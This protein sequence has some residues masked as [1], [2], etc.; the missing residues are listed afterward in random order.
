MVMTRLGRGCS[1]CLQPPLF[2]RNVGHSGSD[3]RRTWFAC[4]KRAKTQGTRLSDHLHTL[5]AIS[6]WSF[7][8]NQPA[9]RRLK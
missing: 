8:G 3:R 5:M 6:A 9:L 1:S 2:N 4:F 7:T